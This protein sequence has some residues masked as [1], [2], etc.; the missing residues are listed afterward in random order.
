MALLL[1]ALLI[2]T[3][4]TTAFS[5]LASRP[6]FLARSMQMSLTTTVPNFLRSSLPLCENRFIEGP[7]APTS[8]ADDPT[9]GMSD[10]D[11]QSYMSNVGGGLC[12]YPEWVKE[13]VGVTLNLSLISFGV[14]TVSY[15]VLY[16]IQLF[17][18]KEVEDTIK[19]ADRG[20]VV[21]K[22]APAFSAL[23]AEG[24]GKFDFTQSLSTDAGADGSNGGLSRK[25]RR[26]KERVKR[27]DNPSQ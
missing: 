7:K 18:D 11:I 6:R 24:S 9:A 10:A 15:V 25:E 2:M 14:F 8:V 12:G 27:N 19:D 23:T 26:L 17:L 16:A 3:S 5:L 20:N 22:G 1:L 13:A 21:P 4:G